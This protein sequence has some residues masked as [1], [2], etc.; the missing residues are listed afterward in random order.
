M[1]VPDTTLEEIAPFVE[2]LRNCPKTGLH[3]PFKNKERY[4]LYGEICK[5]VVVT[6]EDKEVFN[7]FVRCIQRC[8][9]KSTAQAAAELQVT[10]NFFKN[11]CGDRV[12]FLAESFR[13]PGDHQGSFTTAYR[14]PYGR[15]GVIS[16]FN[17]PIEIPV[18]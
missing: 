18:L 4:L 1:Q 12:R 15:V 13:Y 11:F 2:T 10:V 9:P 17:F 8:C 3:N 7:F 6:M 5:N 14:W 16:P